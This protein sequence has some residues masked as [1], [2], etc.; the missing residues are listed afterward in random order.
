MKARSGLAALGAVLAAML[1]APHA[2]A[3]GPGL[4]HATLDGPGIGKPIRIEKHYPYLLDDAVFMHLFGSKS[5][6]DVGRDEPRAGDLGPRFQLRYAMGFGEWVEVALYPYS[7]RG[8]VAYVPPGQSVAVPVG[9]SDEA[10]DFPVHPG[11]YD[12]KPALVELLQSHG[13]P[14]ED[15]TD[16]NSAM[17]VL[18][19]AALGLLLAIVAAARRRGLRTSSSRRGS[20]IG[21]G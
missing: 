7:D 18:P 17:Q 11:W 19:L 16:D 14:H 15:E 3:K 5:R 21:A 13:M 20:P 4:E 10:V 8:P 2:F 12:Y 6:R 9:R 1:A